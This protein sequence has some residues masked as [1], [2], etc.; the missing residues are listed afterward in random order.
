[1]KNIYDKVVEVFI[2]GV[3]HEWEQTSIF[4]N[5]VLLDEAQVISQ[6]YQLSYENF[7]DCYKAIQNGEI[8][9]AEAGKTLFF[10]RLQ[11]SI[12][13]TY[14]NDKYTMTERKF[15]PIFVRTRFELR[16]NLS[17]TYLMKNLSIE[18]FVSY[19]KEYDFSAHR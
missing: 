12:P 19:V 10:N 13:R 9:N 16:K 6:T 3:S 2:K 7:D 1:M 11:I 18:D 15:K 4:Y 17:W 8:Q 14:P 5:D